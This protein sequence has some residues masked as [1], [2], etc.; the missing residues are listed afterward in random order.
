MGTSKETSEMSKRAKKGRKGQTLQKDD[1]LKTFFLL[2]A[3]PKP[4]QTL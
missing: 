3:Y 2:G 1:F 4:A